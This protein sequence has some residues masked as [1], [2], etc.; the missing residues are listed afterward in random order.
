MYAVLRQGSH[1]YRVSPGDVIQIEKIEA[2]K[3]Q[4]VELEDVLMINSAD[5]VELGEPRVTGAA[6]KA[7]V[8]RQDRGKKVLIYKFKR[9]KGY[10]KRQGHRQ[11]FTE[12]QILSI[13]RDGREL[14]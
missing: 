6:V 1:Q 2:E 8:L 13:S 4:E 14:D 12:L 9:R 11:Y 5:G 7:K 3:G 10:E